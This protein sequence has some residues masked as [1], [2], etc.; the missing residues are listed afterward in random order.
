M[1]RN[2]KLGWTI[3]RF[4]NEE[5]AEARRQR[6]KPHETTYLQQH[7]SN[8]FAWKITTP[9]KS[10]PARYDFVDLAFVF[11]NSEAHN[12]NWQWFETRIPTSTFVDCYPWAR[13]LHLLPVAG[14]PIC[15]RLLHQLE[16]CGLVECV[17]SIAQ[18]DEQTAAFLY[19]ELIKQ[20]Q[21]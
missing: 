5:S 16:Q 12:C 6:N 18:E 9:R 10:L 15:K 4:Y 19:Q 21:Q 7:H 2:T 1:I 11:M 8:I 17:V 3:P 13:S 14:I 20:Q